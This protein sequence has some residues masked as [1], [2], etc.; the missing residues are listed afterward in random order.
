MN[1]I[2]LHLTSKFTVGEEVFTLS[3]NL[4]RVE[5]GRISKI[6]LGRVTI[7]RQDFQ[8]PVNFNEFGTVYTVD[9]LSRKGD[10]GT[11]T[12]SQIFKTYDEAAAARI[13]NTGRA[14]GQKKRAIGCAIGDF[15]NAVN[16]NDLADKDRKFY[17]KMA[18]FYKE[19][20]F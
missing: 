12:A 4:R 7:N 20:G 14:F 1:K 6:D 13:L 16:K 2:E 19:E 5:K 10:W 3:A 17:D 15:L 9:N 8:P 18:Q 11:F